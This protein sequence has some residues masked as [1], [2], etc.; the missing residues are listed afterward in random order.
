MASAA[1][2][3]LWRRRVFLVASTM[4]SVVEGCGSVH[5][6]NAIV[7]PGIA[8]TLLQ[9]YLRDAKFRR[10]ELEASLVVP[11]NGYSSLRLGHYDTGVLGDWSLFPEWNPRAAPVTELGPSWSARLGAGSRALYIS[12]A[13]SN[14]D[15]AALRALGEEAFFRYPL[16]LLDSPSGPL[17][18]SVVYDSYG[19]WRDDSRGMGG[20]V[21]APLADGSTAIFLTCASCHAQV[22]EVGRLSPGRPNAHIDLG[23]GFG[24]GRL[25]V[26]TSA[27]LEPVR[28]ADLRPVRFLSHL[29]A[30]ATVTQR[31]VI[32]LAIRIETLIITGR[33]ELLRPPREVALGLALYVWSLADEA[34][35][36]MKLTPAEQRGQAAFGTTCAGCHAT[37][38]N[39]APK[40]GDRTAGRAR[41]GGHGSASWTVGRS[42]N[43]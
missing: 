6:D 23:D 43:R 27:G 36:T 12:T 2:A 22:D 24:P 41:R 28:I 3:L 38:A 31:N 10:A 18:S 19:F 7:D 37:G 8:G 16:Q 39:G 35:H 29:H 20:L 42:R 15:E 4:L 25:D 1:A 13:A 5:E 14:G 40:I 9:R 34:P 26:T 30:D 17:E 21:R 32:S 33:H 11:T